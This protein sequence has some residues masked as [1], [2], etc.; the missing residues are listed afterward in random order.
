MKIEEAVIEIELALAWINWQN[1]SEISDSRQYWIGRIRDSSVTEIERKETINDLANAAKGLSNPLEQAEI[2]VFCGARG[3]L[4]GLVEEAEGWL[5]YAADIYEYCADHHR[6]AT[7]LWI[8]FIIKRGQGKYKQSY[9][10][11]RRSRR[12]FNEIADDCLLKKLIKEESWYRGRVLDM[13]CDLISSPED[14]FECLFEFRGSDLSPSAT[15]IKTRIAAQVEKRNFQRTGDEIQL[16]LGISLRSKNPLET[17]EALAFCGVI[18]WVLEDKS[19][20]IQFFRSAMTQYLPSSFEYAV[21]QWMLGLALFAFPADHYS[22]ISNM[23][24]SI[25]A[26]DKLRQNAIRENKTY[27]SNWFAIHHSAMK[28]ILRTQVEST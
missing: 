5:Q 3:Y 17:A 27:Q 21:I 28:R 4:L 16:L 13:T 20:A 10:L 11:A 2:L 26:F 24:S 25:Q 15:E 23:E 9:D 12:I 8:L 22:A 7:A 14:M 18:S 19:G 1:P 6:H